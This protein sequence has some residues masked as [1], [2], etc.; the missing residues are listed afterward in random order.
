M[1]SDKHVRNALSWMN[2]P[3]T[4]QGYLADKKQA[5]RRTLQQDYAYDPRGGVHMSEVPLYTEMAFPGNVVSAQ[6][7]A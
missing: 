1:R 6:A 2:L 3:L 7:V 5:P 4:L